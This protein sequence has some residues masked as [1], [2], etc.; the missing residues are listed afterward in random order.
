MSANET[1]REFLQAGLAG[2][3]GTVETR[4]LDLVEAYG[5]IANNGVHEPARMILEIRDQQGNVVYRAPDA[6]KRALSAGAAYQVTD[7]LRGN[8]NPRVNPFWGPKLAIRNGPHGERRPAAAAGR[9]GAGTR[10]SSTPTRSSTP[11]SAAIAST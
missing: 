7:I 1:R 3:L 6:G 5:T 2:A 11:T 9:P 8:T 4:P 10:I